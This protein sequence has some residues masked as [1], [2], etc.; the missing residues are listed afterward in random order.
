MKGKTSTKEFVQ[1]TE[2]LKKAVGKYHIAFITQ[3]FHALENVLTHLYQAGII[4]G[5]KKFT[6]YN[7]KYVEVFLRYEPSG[8][9]VLM[10]CKM[11]SKPS[12][13]AYI[14]L[15]QLNAESK[16][17]DTGLGL[18]RTAKFGLTTTHMAL[19]HKTGGLFLAKIF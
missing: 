16:K 3:D 19:K 15:T 8:G 12:R 17:L 11:V 9:P 1:F 5:Y 18:L 13:E 14:R 10:R 6:S 7:K 4:C 2:N